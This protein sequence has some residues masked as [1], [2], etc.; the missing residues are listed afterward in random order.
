MQLMQITV[1]LIYYEPPKNLLKLFI[2]C[3]NQMSDLIKGNKY[4]LSKGNLKL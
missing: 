4:R 3:L 2:Y 1:P